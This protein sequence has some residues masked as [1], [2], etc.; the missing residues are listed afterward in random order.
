MTAFQVPVSSETGDQASRLRE[1]FREKAP[2]APVAS[3]SAP[4]IAVTSGKGGVGKTNLSVNLATLL[5]TRHR[6]TLVD[7]DLG[8]A[9]A[10]ILCGVTPSRRLQHA[11]PLSDGS[12]HGR[13][14][15]HPSAGAN[16]ASICL[17]SPLGF[18]LV[19]GSVGVA[20]MA[21]LHAAEQRQ[22]LRGLA[23]VEAR[24]DLV[25]L[26]TGAGISPGVLGF[27]GVSDL[28]LVVATPEPTSIAD[29]YALIKCFSHRA[30]ESPP[31]ERPGRN[32]TRVALVINQCRSRAEAGSVYRRLLG[33]C[34]RFLGM[35]V[36]LAGV[37]E[38]DARLADAVMARTPVVRFAPGSS[39]SQGLRA[40]AGVIESEWLTGKVDHTPARS[41]RFAALRRLCRF[42]GR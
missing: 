8:M 4:V 1:L 19:P 15:T 32:P 41:G 9:N 13:T 33:A 22:L 31:P 5:A 2:A 11:L 37:I 6:L 28:V 12:V 24:S 34:E 36:P 25:I 16:L 23:A 27:L 39:A 21:D 29:A 38:K 42:E 26:D 3:W 7:A 35:H 18:S 14:G 17:Q 10:D 20:R 30:E 40:L